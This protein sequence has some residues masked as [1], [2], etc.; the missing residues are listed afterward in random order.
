MIHA[1]IQLL[2][3]L[4]RNLNVIHFPISVAIIKL[5]KKLPHK[6]KCCN[7]DNFGRKMA[8][9][10][11][12]VR[13]GNSEKLL[14]P[15]RESG[16]VV[17]GI[18]AHS[19]A[20]RA[21][22]WFLLANMKAEEFHWI[23]VYSNSYRNLENWNF[24]ECQQPC[25]QIVINRQFLPAD[26]QQVARSSSEMSRLNRKFTLVFQAVTHHFYHKNYANN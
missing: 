23:H 4:F 14:G 12:S 2:V 7:W 22:R 1:R 24:N 19:F 8:E 10:W 9:Y 11:S 17:N 16:N 15:V 20:L 6:M 25:C 13:A 3:Q 5:G 18:G 21:G 26:T